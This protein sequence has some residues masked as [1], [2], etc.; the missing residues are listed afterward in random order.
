VSPEQ[1]L[2]LPFAFAMGVTLGAMGSGGSIIT[3]PVLVY[4]AGVAPASAVAMSLAIVGATSAAGAYLHYREGNLHLKAAALLGTTGMAGAYLGT[5]FTRLVPAS[6]LMLIFAIL[7][8]V[9]GL[10]MFREVS[11]EMSPGRCRLIRCAAIGGVVGMLT[12]FLGVGGGFLIVPALVMFAGLNTKTAVGTSL[13]IIA[14]NSASGLAGQI[15]YA[16]VD[17]PLAGLFIGSSMLG[18]VVGLSL[19]R[20]ASTATLSRAFASL[21]IVLAIVIGAMQV[22][23]H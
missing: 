3:L 14:L 23:A 4:V 12:G 1:L 16:Q 11:K 13:A 17:W 7:M 22:A 5:A 9:V 8:L 21:L 6:T 10:A 2:S 20:R 15:R 18:M 19:V